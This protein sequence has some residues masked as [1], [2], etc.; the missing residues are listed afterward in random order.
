[1]YIYVHIIF[2]GHL[3]VE[4]PD[5]IFFYA[6]AFALGGGR[7]ATSWGNFNAHTPWAR[8]RSKSRLRRTFGGRAAV[9]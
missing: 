3:C 4:A 5:D 6:R 9:N 8:P 7:E 2:L 1:M